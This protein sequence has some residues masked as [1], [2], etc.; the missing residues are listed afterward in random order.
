MTPPSPLLGLCRLVVRVV[1]DVLYGH[2]PRRVHRVEE[3]FEMDSYHRMG[4]QRFPFL[5]T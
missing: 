3:K 2:S 1:S 4:A 5:L